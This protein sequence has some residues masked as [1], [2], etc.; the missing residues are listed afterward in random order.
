MAGGGLMRV[1]DFR[2]SAAAFYASYLDDRAE[3]L[4]G[5]TAAEARIYAAAVP[6]G[7]R[8]VVI[9]CGS[10]RDLLPLVAAGHE[11]V[12]IDPAAQ[13]LATLTALLAERQQTA[14]LIHGFIEDVTLPGSFDTII[15]AHTCYSYMPDSSRRRALLARLASHLRPNGFL[16]IHYLY[17]EGSWSQAGR[18][19]AGAIARLCGSD[20]P[21]E[22]YDVVHLVEH[23]SSGILLF[24]HFFLPAELSEEA[25]RA[26]LGPAAGDHFASASGIAVF[27][28]RAD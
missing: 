27:S 11:V 12:G 2:T 1:D 20:V 23:G 7:A 13:P 16:I 22:P 4:Q 19:V 28:R 17:R 14:D 21:W 26:G 9:G 5:L 25:A 3:I 10:G 6:A 18:R 8:I 15:L 24:E